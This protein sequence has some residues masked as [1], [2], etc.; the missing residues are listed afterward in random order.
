MKIYID[1]LNLDILNNISELFKEYLVNT[2]IYIALY[3][4][5]GIYRIEE[6]QT[7]LL[8]VHDK[9]IHSYEKYY[10]GFT[11]I[12]DKSHFIKNKVNSVLG[13]THLSFHTKELYYKLNKKSSLALVLKYTLGD[14]KPTPNDIYFEIDKDIDINE[15]FIK[16]EIIEF[17]SVLN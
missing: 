6:K 12:V 17:L 15:P 7:Y 1:R 14:N 3:T 13:D 11:L 5:E 16:K 10:E 8:D 9:N 2:D 4:S